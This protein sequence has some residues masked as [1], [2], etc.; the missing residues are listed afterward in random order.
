LLMRVMSAHVIA[1]HAAG[2]CC[3]LQHFVTCAVRVAVLAPCTDPQLGG[4]A[5][6]STSAIVTV[7]C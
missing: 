4:L 6:N 2:S 7:L 1:I 5:V 3:D